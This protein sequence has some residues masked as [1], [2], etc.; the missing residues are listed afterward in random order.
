VEVVATEA[1]RDALEGC[2]WVDG[3]LVLDPPR[4]ATDPWFAWLFFKGLRSRG[5]THALDMDL[6]RR[7]TPLACLAA[8][9]P[10]L[11]G[12]KTPGQHRHGLHLLSARFIPG[13][14]EFEQYRDV[15]V[16]AGVPPESLE[17]WPGF[18]QR[19]LKAWK[20]HGLSLPAK[21]PRPY[22]VIHPGC[23]ARDWQRDW[24]EARWAG[25]IHWLAGS[26]WQVVLAGQG[27][28]D[29]ALTARLAQ[30]GQALDLGGQLDYAGLLRLLRRA[31][32][33]ACGDTDILQLAKGL[34]RPWVALHGPSQP[35]KGSLGAAV[36]LSANLACSPCLDLGFE[37]G[38][39]GRA[40]MEA[41][42]AWAVEQ[43]CLAVLR[44]KA[45]A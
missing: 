33:V 31:S 38:C 39:R 5:Y 18:L 32:L 24:P 21:P 2:P 9:A 6:W 41:L 30:D 7:F 29:E 37:Y 19:N 36:A 8:G 3:V 25:L 10:R 43:A 42:P 35:E 28:H 15:A 14:G 44:R 17:A 11:Y 22:V 20:G 40:C 27:A 26:G 12:L 23:G 45:R 13:R 34:G 4:L 1:N 16:L